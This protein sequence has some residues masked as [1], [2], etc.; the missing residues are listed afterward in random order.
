MKK[1]FIAL[2]L[3][4]TILTNAP[5]I[6]HAVCQSGLPLNPITDV[7]WEC[8]FPIEFAGITLIEGPF[9]NNLPSA[10]DVPICEC[11]FPPPIFVRIGLPLSMWEPA[12]FAE[13]VRDP[14]CF[15]SLGIGL[16]SPTI[17]GA[18]STDQSYEA[19]KTYLTFVQAHWFIFPVWT[20]L[21]L[22]SDFACIETS[23]LDITF[24]SEV[25]P[26]WNNDL[27]SFIVSPESL[28]FANPVA[29]EACMVDSASTI[30][31]YSSDPMFWCNA[32][33]NSIYPITGNVVES[34]AL[35]A[36]N[37][38]AARMQFWMLRNISECDTGISLC[39]CVPTP[40]WVKH[41]YRVQL[42][43]PIRDFTCYPFGQT[44]L[45][46]GEAMNPPFVSQ[47]NFVW[48]VF[49]RRTCCVF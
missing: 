27:L 24:L 49:R 45:L 28:L 6:A 42:A 38:A 22:L 41:N 30:G 18:G 17:F 10:A 34:D 7:C 33:G 8:V 44:T 3:L 32:S 9:V 29:Q 1:A 40:I 46:W 26:L 19:T 11:P 20:M 21:E 13:T 43:K 31:G 23:G 47:E 48:M 36:S 37:T 4:M 35:Q 15:P 16:E 5:S 2:V 12:R 39:L 14:F 25:D